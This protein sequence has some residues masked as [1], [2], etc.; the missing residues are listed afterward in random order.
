MKSLRARL[1]LPTALRIPL[2]F[3]PLLASAA[4]LLALLPESL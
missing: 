1:V 4:Y 3:L 2:S